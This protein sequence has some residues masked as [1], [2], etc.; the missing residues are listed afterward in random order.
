MVGC[1]QDSHNNEVVFATRLMPDGTADPNFGDNGVIRIQ[2]S[3]PAALSQISTAVDF[4]ITPTGSILILAHVRNEHDQPC[5]GLIQ[6]TGDGQ[7]D[8]TF[9][10]QGISLI[11]LSEAEPAKSKGSTPSAVKIQPDGDSYKI[12]TFGSATLSENLVEGVAARFGKD[13]SL[14]TTFGVLGVMRIRHQSTASTSRGITSMDAAAIARDGTIVMVGKG[15]PNT[16]ETQCTI[17]R[18]SPDGTMDRNFGD[19]IISPAQPSLGLKHPS[20]ATA[21]AIAPD[22]RIIVA[23]HAKSRQGDRRVFLARHMPDGTHDTTFG[24]DGIFSVQL[25]RGEAQDR[26]S[27]PEDVSLYPDGRIVVGTSISDRRGHQTF[28]FVRLSPNGVRDQSFGKDGIVSLQPCNVAT[29]GHTSALMGIAVG[30]DGHIV[31]TGSGLGNTHHHSRCFL[32]RVLRNGELDGSLGAGGIIKT[33]NDQPIPSDKSYAAAATRQLDGKFVLAGCSANANE[34]PVWA[35]TRFLPNGMPD[36][37][38]GKGGA[39]QLDV[40]HA[41]ATPDPHFR[42][43]TIEIDPNG[44]IIVAGVSKGSGNEICITVV[45]LLDDGKVDPTFGTAGITR[46]RCGT[47]QDAQHHRVWPR[48]L[49]FQS[50]GKLLLVGSTAISEKSHWLIVQLDP[51]GTQNQA[52]GQNGVTTIDASD[53]KST[54]KTSG[55]RAI[56]VLRDNSFVVGGNS[57][58]HLDRNCATLARFNPDGSFQA[59]FGNNGIARL[60]PQVGTTDRASAISST[61][62]A[63]TTQM[64][65]G[66]MKILAAGAAKAPEPK[67]RPL[68]TITRFSSSGKL[69][70]SFGIRGTSA[71]HSYE[72]S[73]AYAVDA[74]SGRIIASGSVVKH[75]ELREA[76]FALNPNGTWDTA[77]GDNGVALTDVRLDDP[78]PER[79]ILGKVFVLSDKIVLGTHG[80]NPHRVSCMALTAFDP[81][82]QTLRTFG[83][84]GSGL[85]DS[86]FRPMHSKRSGAAAAIADRDGSLITAGDA[87]DANGN[88]CI[89]V[90]RFHPTGEVDT[91]FGDNGTRRIQA[92]PPGTSKPD[93]AGRAVA[94]AEDGKIVVTGTAKTTDGTDTIAIVRVQP[95]GTVDSSFGRQGIVL[96]HTL[97]KHPNLKWSIARSVTI[98]ADRSNPRN[99]KIVTAGVAT[100]QNGKP[101]FV[102][103]RLLSNGQLDTQFARTGIAYI[104]AS[105]AN[106]S[107]FSE[108]TSLVIQ[109][110]QKIIVAGQARDAASMPAMALIRLQPNGTPDPSFGTG[111]IVVHQASRLRAAPP[112]PFRLRSGRT[113]PVPPDPD[114]T[115][116]GH[117]SQCPTGA[118]YAT[119]HALV[120]EHQGQFFDGQNPFDHN[121]PQESE[122]NSITI[123][124]GGRIVAAGSAKGPDGDI[125]MAIAQFMP[126]GTLDTTFGNG[127]TTQ[128]QASS[129]PIKISRALGVTTQQGKII[130]TGIAR[131]NGRICSATIRLNPNGQIDETFA[132]KGL[133]LIQ[134]ASGTTTQDQTFTPALTRQTQGRTTKLILAGTTTNANG[135]S[136]H[137]LIRLES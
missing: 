66:E 90:S 104:Q 91:R 47:P 58:D 25:A 6:L 54:I 29:D 2:A 107:K 131:H 118:R 8:T 76:A 39:I 43:N 24:S 89:S 133:A 3:H 67:N 51:D 63:I 109:P 26:R 78:D 68:A 110:D 134:A 85:I 88:R 74:S 12:V 23:L 129:D 34:D 38:F 14:D 92:S 70:T 62:Y 71:C 46:I 137:T 119:A 21:V 20:A 113:L 10:R 97:G 11:Q 135:T 130:A 95:D 94:L 120:D 121:S 45:R 33:H 128:V 114:P 31:G 98:Q 108:A 36:L 79:P 102:V 50:D 52:F 57:R 64:L 122:I 84:H 44:R 105:T 15:G 48:A 127:G 123:V 65:D 132:T 69:D 115:P 87:T 80:S 61:T 86:S 27:T 72:N 117:L 82:G 19:R 17:A 35:V 106:F 7:I 40:K 4:A 37:T 126:D 18:L 9:G 103:M 75:G 77:F 124:A 73:E 28:G 22:G 53:T 56:T 83:D 32:V 112:S 116:T 1:T 59:G 99:S 93:S 111:G 42:A 96:P 55:L 101:C 13:G 125:E 30:P 49:G 100:D 60:Q 136:E 41:N 16:T 5:F 81:N